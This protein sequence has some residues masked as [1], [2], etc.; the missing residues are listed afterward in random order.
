M[1]EAH[2]QPRGRRWWHV[3]GK[4]LLVTALVAGAAP[5]LLMLL[6]LCVPPLLVQGAFV[7][8]QIPPMF[9][10]P[11]VAALAAVLA[12]VYEVRFARLLAAGSCLFLLLGPLSE[13]KPGGPLHGGEIVFA[14]Y[15]LG[16]VAACVL[17]V[18]GLLLWRRKPAPPAAADGP[19]PWSRPAVR[20]SVKRLGLK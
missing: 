9:T 14:V 11:L 17:A 13:F 19:N 2:S 5:G 4:A 15:A 6:L 3:L 8:F 16:G 1:N 18:P 7:L 10:T 12:V 20:P